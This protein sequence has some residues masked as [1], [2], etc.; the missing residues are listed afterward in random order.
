MDGDPGA[1]DG[2]LGAMDGD[3]GGPQGVVKRRKQTKRKA[4]TIPEK[5]DEGML[6]IYSI[7]FPLPV[8][9]CLS[10]YLV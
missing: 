5:K 8:H 1:M 7:G 4:A 2:D 10:L 3:P 6:S 9:A